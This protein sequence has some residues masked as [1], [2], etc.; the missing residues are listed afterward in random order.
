MSERKH[1][2]Y[3]IKDMIYVLYIL[4]KGML[5]QNRICKN[6][7][8]VPFKKTQVWVLT[9]Q[10]NSLEKKTGYATEFYI[11]SSTITHFIILIS[12][13]IIEIQGSVKYDNFSK[14]PCMLESKGTR[15]IRLQ[16]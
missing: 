16:K 11:K 5:K 14:L 9:Q 15:K 12:Y 13:Q 1:N 8:G 4:K 3:V 10:Q 7:Q 2:A 6:I